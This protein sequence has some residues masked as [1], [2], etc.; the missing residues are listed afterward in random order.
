MLEW[1][2]SIHLIQVKRKKKKSMA[3]NKDNILKRRKISSNKC[4]R[5]R[6]NGNLNVCYAI[7]GKCRVSIWSTRLF[8]GWFF[9]DSRLKT[10]QNLRIHHKKY[11]K[12]LPKRCEICLLE[13]SL[14]SEL[15]EHRKTHVKLKVP[16]YLPQQRILHLDERPFECWLCHNRW[17][18]CVEAAQFEFENK[19]N[20]LFRFKTIRILRVHLKIHMIY[21]KIR[22]LK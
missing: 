2:W 15:R 11:C 22:K 6:M 8:D 19:M 13:F 20:R 14:A 21:S 17:V 9:I 5:I 18:K 12:Y 10:K 4:E 7:E 16:K 1:P 3:Q